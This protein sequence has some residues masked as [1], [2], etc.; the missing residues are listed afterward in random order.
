METR[1]YRENGDYIYPQGTILQCA[2]GN[3]YIVLPESDHSPD[4][5][6]M[7]LRPYGHVIHESKVRPLLPLHTDQTSAAD[8][9]Q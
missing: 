4:G 2:E 8:G 3:L 7:E 1:Q 5:S 6:L 9:A